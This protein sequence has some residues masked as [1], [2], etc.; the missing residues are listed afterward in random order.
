MGFANDFISRSDGLDLLGAGFDAGR[1]F[2][3]SNSVITA[4]A[5]VHHT[6]SDKL[7]QN[8]QIQP[9][10]CLALRNIPGA[11]IFAL[12]S[13]EAKIGIDSGD[14]IFELAGGPPGA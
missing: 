4:I 13:A 5:L 11:H 14:A 3:L 7:R 2:A 12:G 6:I 8:V 9:H 1:Q 10:T